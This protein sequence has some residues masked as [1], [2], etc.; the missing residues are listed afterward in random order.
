MGNENDLGGHVGLDTTDFKAGIAELNRQIK[1]I[2]SGFKAAAAGMDDWGAS[3]DGLQ[4]RIK[5]LNDITDLQRKKIESLTEQYKKVAEEK[6]ADSKAAQ[7]LQVRINKETESLNKNQKE[8]QECTNA[9][10]NFGKETDDASDKTSKL[11]GFLGKLGQGLKTAGVTIGKAAAAGIAAVGTAAAGAAAGAYKLAQEVGKTADDLITLSNQT[12]ISTQ[13]LQEWDYAMR[14]I[15]VDVETLT[16]SHAKLIKNMDNAAKGTKDQIEAFE[17]LGV[18]FRDDLTGELRDSQTVFNELMGALGNVENETKRDALAMRLFGKSAQELNPLIKAGTKELERLSKEAHNVG[19]V[20]SDEALEAAGQFDDTMQTLEASTKGLAATLGVAVIPAVSEVVNSVVGIVPKITEAIKTGNWT[21]AG[22]AVA[23]GISGLV[24]KVVAALPGLLDMTT[25]IISN[26]VDSAV[27]I[28][29]KV[30]PSLIQATLQ[31]LD[32]LIKTL[33]DNGP[34]LI[35]TGLDAVMMLIKGIVSALPSLIDAAVEIIFT[36]IDGLIEMFPDL[37]DAALQIVQALADGLIKALPRLV[38]KVPEI[39][40]SIV[41]TL[42]QKLPDIIQSAVQIIVTLAQ[43][44][45]ESL[46]EIIK[47]TVE[48][49]DVL[50]STIIENL[51]L[52]IEAAIEIILAISMAIID[53]LPEIIEATLSIIDTLVDTLL[54]NLPLIIDAAIKIIIA[55]TEGLIDSLP[56][57]IEATIEIVVTLVKT[58]IGNLPKLL[59]AGWEMAKS[60]A[61]G[62]WDG[63]V[64][65]TA[66]V[67]RL[68]ES[69]KGAFGDINWAELGTNMINGIVS[70]VKKAATWLVDS[71]VDAADNALG[72]VKDFL[73]IESPSTV[74]RDQVGAMI[75]AGIAEGITKSVDMVNAA[76]K[77]L[78]R[79]LSIDTDI[80][81]N[82][83]GLNATGSTRKGT[84]ELPRIIEMVIH[85]HIIDKATAEYANNDLLRKLQ[86]RGVEV[87]FR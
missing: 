21:E 59:E 82:T 66:V 12:G 70:G 77:V 25:S 5:A 73:G 8:L 80:N 81:V 57:I 75:G 46:P 36:L 78:N 60:I 86:G 2:D 64:E 72:G 61:Q 3:S 52:I 65:L 28:V 17:E 37:I 50:I 14:F 20:L 62:I 45:I 40:K 6:G 83:A 54:D 49:V 74:M 41:T 32:A 55:L 26:L 22:D 7:D 85:Q 71:V 29:L 69:M 27:D 38:K 24:D 39:I 34:K 56:K 63:A 18:A 42:S 47:A 43:T 4:A 15:D 9:L 53:N 31:L 79:E 35:Q 30:L 33:I 67:P 11:S 84:A 87:A 1:I 10:D 48:L 13:T 19:A 44:M 58:I 16:K 23:S 68:F 76:M 51:P